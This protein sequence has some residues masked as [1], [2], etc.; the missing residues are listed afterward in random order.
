MP[1]TDPKARKS[2]AFGEL[3]RQLRLPTGKSLGEL[4]RHLGYSVVYLSDIE[5]GRR[6]PFD[7]S[8]IR[9]TAAFLGLD[10]EPLL[11]AALHTRGEMIFDVKSQSD[12]ALDVL[13]SLARGKRRDAVYKEVL[14]VLKRD[15]DR[16]R[17]GTK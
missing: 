9:E 16:K 3:L 12:P 8:K 10:P 14:D 15:D 1:P 7:D 4:A 17:R 6:P 11:D 5:R 2:P 13:K